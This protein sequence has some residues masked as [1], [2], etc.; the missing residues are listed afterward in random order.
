M[1]RFLSAHRL[2]PAAVRASC[3]AV[4]REE[5]RRHG[6]LDARPAELAQPAR[7]GPRAARGGRAQNRRRGVVG[8]RRH[9]ARAAVRPAHEPL[10]VDGERTTAETPVGI[11]TT[12]SFYRAATPSRRPPASWRRNGMSAG[13]ASTSSPG[14]GSNRWRR[15]SPCCRPA[16]RSSVGRRVRRVALS[17]SVATPTPELP[18]SPSGPGSPGR[19]ASLATSRADRGLCRWRPNP[20]AGYERSLASPP[21]AILGGY[22]LTRPGLLAPRGV[23]GI[24]EQRKKHEPRRPIPRC[25]SVRRVPPGTGQTSVRIEPRDVFRRV[26][27]QPRRC[28]A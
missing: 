9:P 19:Q 8:P 27:S 20:H 25:S 10:A 7:H 28:G 16:R 3:R 4:T 13:R 26:L 15:R 1:F 17:T 5:E 6:D 24:A 12:K 14:A 21:R 23:W 18:G 2:S 11:V 22:R